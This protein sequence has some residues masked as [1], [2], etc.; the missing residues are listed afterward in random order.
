[1]IQKMKMIKTIKYP[2]RK[3]WQEITKRPVIETASLEKAVKKI[4][5]KVKTK[6]DKAIRK[7]TKEFDGV[8]L[9]KIEVS[10]PMGHP[11]RKSNLGSKPRFRCKLAEIRKIG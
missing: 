1:M 5:E 2:N 11:F 4:L 3:D 8:Q 9:K 7:Y 10:T 6:G